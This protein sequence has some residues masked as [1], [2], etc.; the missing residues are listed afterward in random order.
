MTRLIWD[1]NYEAGVDRGVIYPRNSSA[2]TWNGLIS[3]QES[4]SD[5]AERVVYRDGL[6]VINQRSEDS[7]SAKVEAYTKPLPDEDITISRASRR[8]FD[9]SYRVTTK[10]GHLIHLVY[11][12]TAKKNEQNYA[13]DEA[14]PLGFDL[15]TL[16]IE[17]PEAKSSSHLVIDTEKAYPSVVQQVEDILYGSDVQDAR[18]LYPEEAIDIF[19]ESAILK[20]TNNQ[21]GSFTVTGPDAAIAMLNLDIFEITWPSAVYINGYTYRIRSL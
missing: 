3:V 10:N 16:P 11:N 15:T 21:D 17:I 5:L 9:F 4:P 18:M 8:V 19:E 20:V 14:A 6:R 13:Q 12:A 2:L 7:Y 1:S